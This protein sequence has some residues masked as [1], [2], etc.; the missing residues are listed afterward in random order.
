MSHHLSKSKG[1]PQKATTARNA[2]VATAFPNAT[3]IALDVLNK[4]GNAIDAAVA[5]AFTLSVCEPS[6]SGLGGHTMLMIHLASGETVY[7]DGH[8][9][10]PATVSLKKVKTRQQQLGFRACTVPSMVATLNKA[11]NYYG[12]MNLSDV[13]EPA[14]RLAKDG[15]EITNLQRKQAK[16]CLRDVELQSKKVRILRE[17]RWLDYKRMRQPR[18]ATTLERLARHGAQDFYHGALAHDIDQDMRKNG[19][20]LRDSDLASLRAPITTEPIS[21]AYR[22]YEIVSAAPPGGGLQ[23]LLALKVLE[24]LYE[25]YPN[26]TPSDW[27]VSVALATFAAFEEREKFPVHPDDFTESVKN[28][29]LSDQRAD[30]I[31]CKLAVQRSLVARADADEGPGETTHLCVADEDGNVVSLTQSIQ[32][33]FGARVANWKLGF[34]YNNYLTTCLRHAHAFQLG[35]KCIPRSNVAPTFVFKDGQLILALGA[36]GSRRIISSVLQIITRVTDLGMSLSQAIVA[37]RVHALLNGNVWLEKPAL[38]TTTRSSLSKLFHKVI[39]QR[40]NS[41]VMG[42]VQALAL[43]GDQSKLKSA[44]A[45]PRRDG[46]AEGMGH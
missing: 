46:T 21:I 44:A 42:S 32:S 17:S 8:S 26:P 37:P 29:A 34:L 12:S 9:C 41:F 40:R 6:G 27:Y 13:L 23:L 31:A 7:L 1:Q 36:A 20:L 22:D 5:A 11:L 30:E 25:Q 16:W 39:V 15:F 24:R 38:T 19:G 33:L 45:D 14:I 2:V 4:G 18:L 28:W 10:A 35:G 3:S 43:T